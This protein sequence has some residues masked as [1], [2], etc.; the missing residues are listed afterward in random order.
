MRGRGRACV[1][2]GSRGQPAE[3]VAAWVRRS[4]VAWRHL[5]D[6]ARLEGSH[7]KLNAQ[8]PY[9]ASASCLHF[10]DEE[11]DPRKRLGSDQSCISEFWHLGPDPA[12]SGMV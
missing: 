3:E 4:P 8:A 5:G 2:G 11:T 6:T 10:T 12:L 1:G 7:R 9:K